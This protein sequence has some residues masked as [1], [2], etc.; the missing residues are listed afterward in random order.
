M[1][2]GRVTPV[3]AGAVADVMACGASRSDRERALQIEPVSAPKG[4]SA[5]LARRRLLDRALLSDFLISE[6][7]ASPSVA[8]LRHFRSGLLSRP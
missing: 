5:D 1:E 3:R 7:H 6:R 8:P 4:L 2:V